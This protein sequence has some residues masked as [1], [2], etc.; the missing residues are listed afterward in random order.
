MTTDM[1]TTP[2]TSEQFAAFVQKVRDANASLRSVATVLRGSDQLARERLTAASALREGIDEI[3]A[4]GGKMHCVREPE[5]AVD[6]LPCDVDAVAGRI[7]AEALHNVAKHAD[8]AE[9]CV[10][11]IERALH[12]LDFVVANRIPPKPPSMTGGMGLLDSS[13]H[14]PRS[15]EGLQPPRLKDRTGYAWSRYPSKTKRR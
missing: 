5:G 14:T 15:L 7:L 8:L 11:S 1:M 6:N 10:V 9:P 13:V 2:P 4:A 3:E 12:R